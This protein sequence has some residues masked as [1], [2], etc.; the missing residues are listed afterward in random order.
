[1]MRADLV[2]EEIGILRDTIRANDGSNVA[3]GP[4]KRKVEQLISDFYDEVGELTALRLSDI[5]DLFLIKVLYVDRKSRDAETLWYLGRLMERYLNASNLSLGPGQGFVPYLSDLMEETSHPSGTHQN[6]FETYRKYG[7]NALFI[8]GLFPDSIGRRRPAGRLGGSPFVDKRY[9]I[10]VGRSFYER[11]AG[12]Q[13]AETVSL[14]TTLLRLAQ[15]FDL[16]VEALNEMSSRY[17]LGMDMSL[18]A[19]KMLDAFNL[20]RQTH[21][22]KYLDA[23]RKYAA[24]LKLDGRQ[25]PGLDQ[26]ALDLRW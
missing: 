26:A 6:L 24:L 1:M 7:D 19:D 13:L 21:E 20:Y 17:V 8:S 23:A 18:I 4:F 22:A 25:W 5:L 14:R 10:T 12:E 16:Y 15:W 11:A 2:A 3:A 9:F